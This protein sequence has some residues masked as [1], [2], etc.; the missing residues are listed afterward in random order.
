MQ[1]AVWFGECVVAT[2]P[3]VSRIM[4]TTLILRASPGCFPKY[5]DDAH[6]IL[7]PEPSGDTKPRGAGYYTRARLLGLDFNAG[8][9]MGDKTR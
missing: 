7:I 5:E 9:S 3:G 8:G 1:Q 4:R 6:T 2:F